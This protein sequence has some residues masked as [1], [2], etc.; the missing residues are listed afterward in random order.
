MHK[1]LQLLTLLFTFASFCGWA[2]QTRVVHSVPIREVTPFVLPQVDLQFRAEMDTLL[3][4]ASVEDCSNSVTS[5]G[6]NGNWGLVAGTNGYG[7][8]EKAQRLTYTANS[9]YRVTEVWGF[10]AEA[11]VVGNGTLKAKVYAADAANGG[12]GTLLGTSGLVNTTNVKTDAQ[13]VPAT[14]FPFSTPAKV[15]TDEFFI[16]IDFSALYAAQDTVG[17]FHTAQDCGSG[18][19]TW[20]LF[21][22]GTTWT[23]INS[24][25]SWQFNANWIMGAVVEFDAST[26]VNDPFVAQNGLQLFPATPNPTNDWVKLPYQLESATT[27]NIE[28]YSADGKLLQRMQKGEQLAGRYAEQMNTQ[29]LANGTYVYRIVTEEASIMSRFVVSH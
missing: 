15:S 13:G 27:V 11:I 10:F 14:I 5:F 7:D 29:S 23:A 1:K 16:S 8:R 19:D 2:Q 12:P 6:I 3:F 24:A 25:I 26:S 17:L 22:D 21:S 9:P 4:S 28:V 18:D 20:E